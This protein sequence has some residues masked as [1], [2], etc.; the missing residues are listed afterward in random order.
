MAPAPRAAGGRGTAG[1][2][3]GFVQFFLAGADS[4]N[5]TEY[6]AGI[7][8]ALKL[9]NSRVT[10][11]PALVRQFAGPRDTPAQAIEKIYLAALSRRP[12]DAEI[13]RLTEYVSKAKSPMD[14]YGDIL[15][16]VF[17]SSE[18]TMIK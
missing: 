2:R 5:P 11:N 9:M 12:T 17:N 15:W 1:P 4:A 16:V 3:D 18:F 6:E 14:A 8:Q 10:G 7:P 13:K